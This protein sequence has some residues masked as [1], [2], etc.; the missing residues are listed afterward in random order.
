MIFDNFPTEE[1]YDGSY[2]IDV[3]SKDMAENENSESLD[4]SVNRFGSVFSIENADEI[5]GKY[6]NKAPMIVIT[7]TNV[8]KHS[9]EDEVI[10]IIDKGSNTV[11]LTDNE[12][13]IS[14]PKELDDKSGYV[15]TYTIDPKNFD[16]DLDYNIS[17]QSVDAAGNKNVSSGRG[18]D[19]SFSIDTHEPEFKC[20]EL[21]DRAE[22]KESQREFK[23]NVNERLSHVKVT[24][25]LNE[26]LL[27]RD[28]NDSGDNSYSFA[29]PASNTSRDLT[30]ELT[31]LAGNSTVKTYNNLLITE[32]IALYVMHKTWAKAGAAAAAALAAVA[33]GAVLIKKKKDN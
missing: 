23:L 25:S 12:Y 24:T 31:D 1:E 16:Q 19:L 32:N 20:D 29:V 5:N 13:V 10:I 17:I 2:R 28:G 7:E 27:D 15:Y 8:D 4:F 3:E 14:G 18:A 21:I 33:G 22:F 11:Q 6:L 26:V 30:V 9:D